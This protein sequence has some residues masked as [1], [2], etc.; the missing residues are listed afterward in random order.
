[1]QPL[2]GVPLRIHHVI[3]CCC[4]WR[5]LNDKSHCASCQ[6]LTTIMLLQERL[7]WFRSVRFRR[8]RHRE[9]RHKVKMPSEV[10]YFTFAILAIVTPVYCNDFFAYG[11]SGL[12]TRIFQSFENVPAN[13]EGTNRWCFACFSWWSPAQASQDILVRSTKFEL[14]AD[15]LAGMGCFSGQL[16][17]KGIFWIQVGDFFVPEDCRLVLSAMVSTAWCGANVA[18]HIC[19]NLQFT[20]LYVLN[21]SC[22]F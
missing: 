13:F 8:Q 17:W 14:K 4:G 12:L 16:F 22:W 21:Y 11:L 20:G 10:S 9:Q 2:V 19:V 15:Y 6:L 5:I 7:M 18:C 3:S 1:M